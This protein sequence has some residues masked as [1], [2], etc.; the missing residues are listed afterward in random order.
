MTIYIVRSPEPVSGKVCDVSFDVGRATV[1]SE[2]H[3]AA[4]AYFRKAGY[5]VEPSRDAAE[6]PERA[7]ESLD[8]AQALDP[9]DG[10]PSPPAKKSTPDKAPDG[11]STTT[12]AKG[13]TK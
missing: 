11:K 8:G 2:T 12:N 13:V 3:R 5:Q 9:P 4:L 10:D 6:N 7:T 1:N